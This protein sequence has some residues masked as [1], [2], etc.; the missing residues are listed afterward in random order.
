MKKLSIL[1]VILLFIGCSTG[2]WT[3]SGKGSLPYIEEPILTT[4]LFGSDQ[5]ILDDE[6]INTILTGKIVL[7]QNAK[8]A[9]IKFPSIQEQRQG[10]YYYGYSYWQSEEYHNAQE[11]FFETLKKPL[12]LSR[13]TS[14]VVLLPTLM[15]PEKTSISI[16]R[17]AAARGAVTERESSGA[18]R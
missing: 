3:T 14:D 4:S 11:R 7:P 10:G 15:V 9:I 12:L 16:L 18:G 17:E 1:P 6:A 5:S 13:K 2:K 8:I